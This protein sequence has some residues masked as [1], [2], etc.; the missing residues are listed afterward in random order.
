MGV[1]YR[2][3]KSENPFWEATSGQQRSGGIAVMVTWETRS[4]YELL[5]SRSLCLTC[6]NSC[7]NLVPD[8]QFTPESMLKDGLNPLFTTL[9]YSP[10]FLLG[11]ANSLS[12][13]SYARS[14][15]AIGVL[16]T[17][18]YASINPG[19][20]SPVGTMSGHTALMVKLC[21]GLRG[22]RVREA[23]DH[24]AEAV[25]KIAPGDD[26]VGEGVVREGFDTGV[27]A[28]EVDAEGVEVGFGWEKGGGGAEGMEDVVAVVYAG[29]EGGDVEAAAPGVGESE[30]GG[31]AG[32]GGDVNADEE[33][34]CGGEVGRRGWGVEV[35]EDDVVVL[36]VC[37]LLSEYLQVWF[38]VWAERDAFEPNLNLNRKTLEIS[39][40][41]SIDQVFE[42]EIWVTHRYDAVHRMQA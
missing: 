29:V 38:S 5:D 24:A 25:T 8:G 1:Q 14:V 42:P 6:H 20:A 2:V 23:D 31:L 17:A 10:Q 39:W 33:G 30:G 13:S 19:G 7:L 32:L 12:S 28:E 21:G 3:Q 11:Y 26:L 9:A 4:W 41:A 35:Q 36:A 22:K 27:D 16:A 18:G 34:V 15:V 40:C 37:P